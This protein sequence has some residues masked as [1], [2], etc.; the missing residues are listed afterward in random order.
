MK[1]NFYDDESKRVCVGCIGESFLQ[2]KIAVE[3]AGKCSYCDETSSPC[4]EVEELAT[5]VESAFEAH[6]ERTAEEP[7]AFESA[8]HRDSEIDYDWDR[9]GDPILDVIADILGCEEN[10]ASDVL[11]ILNVKYDNRDPSDSHDECEFAFDSYYIRKSSSAGDWDELWLRLEHAL[12]H[13]SRL[14]NQEALTIL[15]S[16]FADLHKTRSR[17]N[18]LALIKAGLGENISALY[19]AREFYSAESL[20]SALV[21]PVEE[22][23]PPPGRLA[24]PGRMNSSGI[25]VFYGALDLGSALAE[26]RPVVGSN[27]VTA[28]FN[29][30]R[31]VTLLDLRALE[32]LRCEGSIFNPLYAKELARHDFLQTLSKRLVLPVM[33]NEQDHEYLITQAVADYLASLQTPNVDGIIFPSVQDGVGVNVVLF[34]KAAC[35][36]SLGYPPST[37]FNA[38]VVDYDPDTGDVYPCYTLQINQ[39]AVPTEKAEFDFPFLDSYDSSQIHAKHREPFL[40]LDLQTLQVHAIKA[41]EVKAE[42]K[43]VMVRVDTASPNR[44]LHFS[45]DD[46]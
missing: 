11:E 29:I 35:V 34:H 24:K 31:P 40:R 9:E 10:I 2:G 37:E 30:I 45:A 3:V 5:Q 4:I 18:G 43:A 8:M 22:L 21:K 44:K 14:F 28:K 13:E 17:T 41:V 42:A 20:Q 1:N 33:P 6:Y 39:P 25:A 12:K 32:G 27:V 7:N 26:V 15:N 16:V 46:F 19:R 23:G 36:E 38:Q